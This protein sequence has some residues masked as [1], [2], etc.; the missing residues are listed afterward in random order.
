MKHPLKKPC[1]RLYEKPLLVDTNHIINIPF[2]HN[3]YPATI[4]HTLLAYMQPEDFILIVYREMHD[5]EFCVIDNNKTESSHI[6]Q[7]EGVNN[8]QARMLRNRFKLNKEDD[9]GSYIHKTNGTLIKFA[10]E[11]LMLLANVMGLRSVLVGDKV[12]I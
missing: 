2:T 8:Y 9:D 12:I 11:E 4:T 6:V 3:G 5:M 1:Q 7:R 10:T